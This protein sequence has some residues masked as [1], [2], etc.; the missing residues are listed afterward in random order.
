MEKF[1]FKIVENKKDL[2]AY[3]KLRH[4]VFVKEQAIFDETDLDECD[5]EPFHKAVHVVALKES[6]GQI[7]GAV[8]CYRKEG[9]TWFGGRLSASK[10]YRNGRVGVG[11][12][13]FAVSIM[14]KENCSKFLAYVQPQNVKF[15]VRLGW[16]S[17]G[18]PEI[19]H[20]LSHQLMEACLD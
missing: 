8:R 10:G 19:Y 18:E 4:N 1:V 16:K 17:I 20:G 9:T 15:F 3:F 2:E 13:K 14:K 11:L 6:D 12:I 7:V 5:T